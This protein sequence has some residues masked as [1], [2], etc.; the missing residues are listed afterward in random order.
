LLQP[1]NRVDS[2][3]PYQKEGVEWLTT[4]RFALLADEPGL[5]KSAQA[6]VA[7]D[8]IR[9]E[10]VV[11]L[12]PASVRVNWARQW[13]MWGSGIADVLLSR[14]D[15]IS[16]HCRV[17]VSSYDGTLAP[18]ILR[19]LTAFNPTLLVLDE[20]HYLK[21]IDARRSHAVLGKSGLVHCAQRTWALSGTPAPNH[22]GELYP[23]LRV[24]GAIRHDHESF[25]S[26]F[27][28]VRQTQFGPQIVGSKN[29]PELRQILAPVMLRRRKK[30]VMT[31]LP[32]IRFDDVVVEPGPIDEE[33]FF[34]DYFATK[35]VQKLYDDVQAQRSAVEQVVQFTSGRDQLTVMEGMAKSVS[36]LRRYIGLQKC[37]AVIDMV[38]QELRD[39]AYEKI[40]L[41]TCHRDVTV[42][43]QEGL[44]KFKPVTLYGG[45]PPATRQANIDK[46]RKQKYCR[47][48]IGNI[49][50]A[51][52]G[53]DGLQDVCS[54]VGMV[55]CSWTPAENAQAVMR[56]HRIGQ[57]NPVRVRV[58]SV[59]DSIDEHVQRRLR[60]KA[61]ELTQ[62]FD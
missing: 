50:A 40:V 24:F 12:C 55:E 3:Y 32:P 29:I 1:K 17:A 30:D 51:G 41:F 2:L 45:T 20:S 5:G 60:R 19:R 11:L 54:E 16:T 56:L 42:T 33:R 52:T 36:T 28:A 44:A 43:L 23:L 37:A 10:R 34:Y 59:A 31:Q 15:T 57:A 38:A 26:R 21:S 35:Q 27:C 39:H 58:F 49:R 53:I 62:I 4:K 22:A 25:V 8:R 9:A 61:A 47:V 18:E 48:F 13:S 6:A 14:R 46:F 7:A